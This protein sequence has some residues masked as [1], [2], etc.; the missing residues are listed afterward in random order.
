[1]M[2]PNWGVHVPSTCETNLKMFYQLFVVEFPDFCK[3]VFRYC[4][5]MASGVSVM[6][7]SRCLTI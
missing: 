3:I 7:F 1:M 4:I 2:K 6:D 5:P